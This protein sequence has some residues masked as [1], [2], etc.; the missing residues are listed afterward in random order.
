MTVWILFPYWALCFQVG[1]GLSLLTPAGRIPRGHSVLS[2]ESREQARPSTG[3]LA[4]LGSRPPLCLCL[5]GD[6][7]DMEG[8]MGA[9]SSEKSVPSLWAFWSRNSAMWLKPW[10][11]LPSQN[12]EPIPLTPIWAPDAPAM[13]PCIF[14]S[15]IIHYIIIYCV[16]YINYVIVNNL[17][18]FWSW[19]QIF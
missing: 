15:L 14:I 9:T 8:T 2:G 11:T 18:L 13:Y 5:G 3:A 1:E 17:S 4:R 10:E 6:G 7:E 12:Q 16:L 19:I